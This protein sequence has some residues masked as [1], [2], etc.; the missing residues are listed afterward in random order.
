[1][2]RFAWPSLTVVFVAL[3]AVAGCS[4]A[5]AAP[6]PHRP[7]G[8]GL[9]TRLILQSSVLHLGAST[10]ATLVITNRTGRSVSLNAPDGCQPLWSIVLANRSHPADGAFTAVCIAG[11]LV[12]P[13]GI[14]RWPTTLWAEADS[15]PSALTP[16]VYTAVLVSDGLALPAPDPVRVRVR[17]P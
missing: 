17:S 1:M 13:P 2:R 11:P 5:G 12:V 15:P 9:S 4:A 10:G 6:P 14:T 7:T 16:G 3:G 8:G